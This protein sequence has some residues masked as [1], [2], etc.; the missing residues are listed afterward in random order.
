MIKLFGNSKISVTFALSSRQ[1]IKSLYTMKTY[2]ELKKNITETYN[3]YLEIREKNN[4][5]QDNGLVDYDLIDELFKLEGV[6]KR[7]I[8]HI[9][10]RYYSEMGWSKEDVERWINYLRKDECGWCWKREFDYTFKYV[11]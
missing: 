6:F 9:Y 5:L 11:A 2:T 10:K 1:N 7:Q 4:E 8:I 3:K